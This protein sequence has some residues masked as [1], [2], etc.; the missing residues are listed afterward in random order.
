MFNSRWSDAS[1]AMAGCLC[2]V[3]ASCR[4]DAGAPSSL[5]A[6]DPAPSVAT[7]S[8]LAP[9]ISAPPLPVASALGQDG[10]CGAAPPTG[11]PLPRLEQHKLAKEQQGRYRF[12]LKYPLFHEE[13]EKVT[14][15]LNRQ[16]LEQLAA[17]Q[18]RF[19]SEAEGQSGALDPD[20]PRWFEGKCEVAYHSTSFVSI[21]CDT[22]EGPGAHPNLDKFAYNFQICP[23]VRMLGLAD[24]CRSLS[25]CR[26]GIVQLINE[27]FRTGEKK[28]TGIQFR[29]GPTSNGEPAG[30]EHPVATLRTFGI[31]PTGLRTY[32][33]D[34]LPHV[35]KAFGVVDLPAARLRPLLR[36]DVARRIW[37]I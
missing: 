33:F 23:E 13:N 25:E 16:V 26:K 31:T 37:G 9:S 21:A 19:V 18:K 12:E 14:Q 1:A 36:D 2:L 3:V 28:Q 30:S 15:K 8:S 20:N 32:L 22:M 7:K 34:E 24:L 29:D 10:N 35:L 6:G 4:N 11:A 27:D 17:I 5:T